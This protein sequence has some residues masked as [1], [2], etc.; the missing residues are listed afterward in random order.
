VLGAFQV[1]AGK[2]KIVPRCSHPLT[3]L[4]CVSRIYTALVVL[5]ITPARAPK[6]CRR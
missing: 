3:G 4:G 5:D 2:S 6:R 1:S